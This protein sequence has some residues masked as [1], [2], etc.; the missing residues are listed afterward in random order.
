M[1]YNEKDKSITI[2]IQEYSKIINNLKIA[3]DKINELE[4]FF[5]S[6]NIEMIKID[7]NCNTEISNMEFELK[8]MY[9]DEQITHKQYK[10][11][12]YIYENQYF[13]DA[14]ISK[15]TNV[16]YSSISQWKKKDNKFKEMYYKILS[17][18]SI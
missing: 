8:K 15:S 9:K 11:L 5:L 7:E 12:K 18:K 2:N 16:S 14:E 17:F 10:V 13:S 1:K 4:R 6:H 3:Y